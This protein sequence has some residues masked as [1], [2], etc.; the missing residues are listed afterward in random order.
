MPE[1]IVIT[2]TENDEETDTA[3]ESE[4]SMRFLNTYTDCLEM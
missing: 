1:S 2:L 3:N 4:D